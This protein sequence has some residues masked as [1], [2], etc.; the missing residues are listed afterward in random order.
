MYHRVRAR[1][2]FNSAAARRYNVRSDEGRGDLRCSRND[3]APITTIASSPIAVTGIVA[4]VLADVFLQT[5]ARKSTCE[6]KI[7]G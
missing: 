6:M 2:T 4:R 1:A 3:R 7:R 5:K